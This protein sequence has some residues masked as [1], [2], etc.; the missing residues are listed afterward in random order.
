MDAVVL[1]VTRLLLLALLYLFLWRVVRVMAADLRT[2]TTG[3]RDAATAASGARRGTA[4]G[5]AERTV[6]SPRSAPSQLVVHEPSGAVTTVDLGS[7]PVVLGRAAAATVVVEDEF[8][9]DE[10]TAFTPTSGGWTVTDLGSTNGTH[11]NGAKVAIATP[12]AAGDQVR[13][14][15][16]RVEVRR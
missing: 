10:H 9:S 4:Q 7:E 13:V 6:P 5:D 14:G 8:V 3:G 1:A 2:P 15:K 16:T 11:L 12:V